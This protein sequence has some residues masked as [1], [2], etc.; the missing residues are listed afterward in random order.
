MENQVKIAPAVTAASRFAHQIQRFKQRR[1]L[2][3]DDFADFRHSLKKTLEEFG[4]VH[5]DSAGS[6][7]EALN[8]FR[9]QPYDVVIA[10]YNLGDG[11]DGQQLLEEL[12]GADLLRPDAAYVMLTAENASSLVLGAL[13]HRPDDYLTKPFTKP[14]LL[15]RL[16]RAIERKELLAPLVKA[17]QQC[18]LEQVPL[19]CQRVAEQHPRLAPAIFRLSSEH[20]MRAGAAATAASL[21]QQINAQQTQGWALCGLAW[22]ALENQNPEHALALCQQAL[23]LNPDSVD[24]FDL[25]AE[26]LLRSGDNSAAFVALQEAAKRSPRSLGRQRRLAQLARQQGDWPLTYRAAKRT[27]ELSPHGRQGDP[28]DLALLADALF[29][30]AEQGDSRQQRRM[31]EEMSNLLLANSKRQAA[32]PATDWTLQALRMRQLAKREKI[33][34]AVKIWNDLKPLLPLFCAVQLLALIRHLVPALEGIEPTISRQLAQW[35][36]GQ[37]E[38]VNNSDNALPD[39]RIGLHCYQQGDLELAVRAFNAA[40]QQRP[41]SATIALNLLQSSLK[42]ARQRDLDNAELQACRRALLIASR[43]PSHDSR[44]PRFQQLHAAAQQLIAAEDSPE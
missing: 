27:L 4:A 9:R 5:I 42:L 14:T 10:D 21:L 16:D 34:E 20:L 37:Q 35:L 18:P 32:S 36:N 2:L 13:E 39:N 3:V 29:T 11:K 19:L 23:E 22:C 7:D 43:L 1:F 38:N 8:L 26:A 30:L 31:G 24:A 17:L 44:Y 12:I 6:A 33:A 25:Q 28:E 40:L 41:D 15:A